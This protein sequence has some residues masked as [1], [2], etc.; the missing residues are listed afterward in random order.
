[1]AS[2]S[3][4]YF[5]VSY[6]SLHLE[7]CT[8]RPFLRD[9]S[10]KHLP[11]PRAP[12]NPRSPRDSQTNY[13]QRSSAP[14]LLL[15]STFPGTEPQTFHGAT[16]KLLT[17]LKATPPP[18]LQTCHPQP[19]PHSPPG[20]TMRSSVLRPRLARAAETT[21][22]TVEPST[23]AVDTQMTGYLVASVSAT[24]SAVAL[25]S[26][27]TLTRRAECLVSHFED[28]LNDRTF[29]LDSVLGLIALQLPPRH[30]SR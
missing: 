17:S 21:S 1:M 28:V 25:R 19:R 14:S 27:V 24:L 20:R 3:G 10:P 12:I 30:F 11:L 4:C 8:L 22:A 26:F 13:P 15:P 9:H 18:A 2:S 23:T 7:Q 16:P 5:L 29:F 6:S